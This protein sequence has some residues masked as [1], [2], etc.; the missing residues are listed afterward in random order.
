MLPQCF[1]KINKQGVTF[2]NC[3]PLQD[4]YELRFGQLTV[5]QISHFHLASFFL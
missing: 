1:D 3:L 2:G 5:Y 4:C